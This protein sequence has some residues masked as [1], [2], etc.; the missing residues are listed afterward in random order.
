[1]TCRAPAWSLAIIPLCRSNSK[2]ACIVVIDELNA[3]FFECRL[4]FLVRLK[5]SPSAASDPPDYSDNLIVQLRIATQPLNRRRYEKR[6]GRPSK[7]VQ[8]RIRHPMIRCM[9]ATLDG[10]VA[11]LMR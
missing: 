3:G 10:I 5:H 11:G 7:A 2:A 4:T 8:S 1:M 9:A 6:P